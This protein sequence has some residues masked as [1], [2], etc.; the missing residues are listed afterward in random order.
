MKSFSIVALSFSIIPLISAA[1]SSSETDDLPTYSNITQDANPHDMS[2]ESG[3]GLLELTAG[4]MMY[5]NDESQY[6][7]RYDEQNQDEQRQK[8]GLVQIEQQN[9]G[10]WEFAKRS[11]GE[12]FKK[13]KRG[14]SKLTGEQAC[15]EGRNYCVAFAY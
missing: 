11:V 8:R 7:V 13:V 2:T 6:I 10:T 9:D 5:Q 12:A 4:M 15:W 1:S 14:S 3:E